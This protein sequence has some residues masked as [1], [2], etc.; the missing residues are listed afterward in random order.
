LSFKIAFLSTLTIILLIFVFGNL[1]YPQ[2]KQNIQAT[3]DYLTVDT[4]TID[5]GRIFS[6][7]TST[8]TV[9]ATS[10]CNATLT[11]VLANCNYVDLD[12]YLSITVAPNILTANQSTI[13]QLTLTSK[14][15]TPAFSFNADIM[16]TAQES[17]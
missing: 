17:Q 10:T 12:K 14:V 16:L 4:Q 9:N 7:G 8:R 5:W 6:G 2:P 15:G 3:P 11:V 1:F 13:L